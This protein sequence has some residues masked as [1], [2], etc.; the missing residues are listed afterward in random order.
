[1]RWSELIEAVRRTGQYPTAE[2]AE[3]VAGVV[4]SALGGQVTGEERVDLARRLPPEA[5]RLIADQVPEVR[6]HTAPEFVE[7][8]ARRLEG[9]TP[10]TARWD[11]SSVL[12]VLSDAAGDELVDRLLGLLPSGYALL[13]GRAELAPAA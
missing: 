1:M 6:P 13:F 7:S 3:R 8:V 2:E 4:L 9:A 10:A 5:A 11:V 12:A